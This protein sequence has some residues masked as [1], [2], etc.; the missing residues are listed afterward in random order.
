MP[1]RPSL[2]TGDAGRLLTVEEAA[3]LLAVSPDTIAS[4]VSNKTIPYIVLP[5]GE[6]RQYRIPLRGLLATLAGGEDGDERQSL[7]EAVRAAGI[8]ASEI[9]AAIGGEG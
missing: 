6:R 8:D 1:S 5:G 3:R 2:H 4:W 9:E 7:D